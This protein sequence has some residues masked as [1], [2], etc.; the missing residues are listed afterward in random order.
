MKQPQSKSQ[1]RI[2]QLA[3][4]FNLNPK[5]IRYYEEIGLL[6]PADR[7]ANGYRVY[8]ED[9]RCRLHFIRQAKVVGLTLEEI[10]EVLAIRRNG[11]L[12][13][14]HVTQLLDQK[15]VTIDEQL[16]TLTDFRQALL[17]LRESADTL[18]N[19]DACVCGIIEQH[20]R[21][22]PGE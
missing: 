5:T 18:T 1:V 9:D 16:R 3:A 14:T 7:A 15:L 8:N 6:P 17:D 12:P 13:C 19:A 10:G 4:E 21:C 20:S 11:A 22:I 2:G